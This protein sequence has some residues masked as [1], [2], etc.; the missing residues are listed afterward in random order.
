MYFLLPK[1]NAISKN[2]FNFTSELLYSEFLVSILISFYIQSFQCFL[3]NYLRICVS[4]YVCFKKQKKFLNFNRFSL[5]SLKYF[6]LQIKLVWFET[7]NFKFGLTSENEVFYI[8]E[9]LH[10][11][12]YAQNISKIFTFREY[13][14]KM[15]SSSGVLRFLILFF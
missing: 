15:Y 4:M 12:E 14:E 9:I 10:F 5:I 13:F 6:K 2:M 11:V 8:S 3:F 1:W 7:W